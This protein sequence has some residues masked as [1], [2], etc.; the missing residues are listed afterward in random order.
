[1]QHLDGMEQACGDCRTH[2]QSLKAMGFDVTDREGMNE[3]RQYS[4]NRV[5]EIGRQAADDQGQG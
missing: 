5:R 2:L 3:Q 4:V 1:M